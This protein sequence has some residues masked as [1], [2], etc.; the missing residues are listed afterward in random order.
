MAEDEINEI[1]DEE[2]DESENDIVELAHTEICSGVPIKVYIMKNGAYTANINDE[3]FE[4]DTRKQLFN[5]M[6]IEWA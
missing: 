2:Q 3:W 6:G 4:G 5:E 1:E